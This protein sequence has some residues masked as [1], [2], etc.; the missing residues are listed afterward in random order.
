[1]WYFGYTDTGHSSTTT[2][3]FRWIK[4]TILTGR[5]DN[6]ISQGT[7]IY[8]HFGDYINM[9]LRYDYT[10]ILG[11]DF[12]KIVIYDTTSGWIITITNLYV[13]GRGAI[14]QFQSE[15]FNTQN[16]LKGIINSAE[17]MD[18]SKAWHAWTTASGIQGNALCVNN[19]NSSPRDWKFGTIINGVCSLP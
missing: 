8:P 11:Q 10:N 5:Q 15:S 17:Y 3:A 9:T 16:V 19:I 12:Y 4:S 6:D 1:M 13:Y 18:T 2:P 7:G 14:T